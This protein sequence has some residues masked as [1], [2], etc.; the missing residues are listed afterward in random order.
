MKALVT[1]G[2]GFLGLYIVEQLRQQGDDVRVFCRGTY[3]VLQQLNVEIVNGDVRDARQ[4]LAACQSMDAVF[5]VAAVPGVWGQWKMFHD[6]NTLGTHNVISACLEQR[7]SRL[8]YTSSPSV[9]FDGHDHI[10]ADE[11]LP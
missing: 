9:V 7:V 2:G 11:S 1:G 3:P 10:N 5:H 6:I 4:V 8:I